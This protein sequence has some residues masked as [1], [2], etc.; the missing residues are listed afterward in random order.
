MRT[1]SKVGILMATLS[2]WSGKLAYVNY[3]GVFVLISDDWS[4]V[5]KLDF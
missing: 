3:T 2:L 1:L 4:M 5:Q